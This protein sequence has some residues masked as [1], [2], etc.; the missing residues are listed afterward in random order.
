MHNEYTKNPTQ[1]ADTTQQ[2]AQLAEPF[3]WCLGS[4]NH[5][6]LAYA[7]TQAMAAS[8]TSNKGLHGSV[9]P[10]V[11]MLGTASSWH[12]LQHDVKVWHMRLSTRFEHRFIFGATVGEDH[13]QNKRHIASETGD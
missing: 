4:A 12:T 11:D 13:V 9:V 1:G 2:H 3:F 7:H 8:P 10:P 5:I 6:V